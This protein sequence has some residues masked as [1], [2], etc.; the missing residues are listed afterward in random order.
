MSMELAQI[1]CGLKLDEL[2]TQMED[3]V[4]HQGWFTAM[5]IVFSIWVKTRRAMD[6]YWGQFT[7]PSDLLGASGLKM[8]WGAHSRNSG[9]FCT[10]FLARALKALLAESASWN[11]T[12]ARVFVS[13]R[14][15]REM[16]P[17]LPNKSCTQ[18]ILKSVT[19]SSTIVVNKRLLLALQQ[20]WRDCQNSVLGDQSYSKKWEL[21]QWHEVRF[22]ILAAKLQTF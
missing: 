11:S 20:Q 15:S 5:G 14:T 2:V 8:P 16:I 7:C 9:T 22:E 21:S 1:W 6:T 12:S 19:P 3:P 4:T 10:R 17:C 18:T 13:G